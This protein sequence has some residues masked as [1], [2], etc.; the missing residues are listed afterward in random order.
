MSFTVH[1]VVTYTDLE[2]DVKNIDF[3]HCTI[4]ESVKKTV[5]LTNKSILPQQ[6]GFVGV[7]Q[8]SGHDTG[9]RSKWRQTKTYCQSMFFIALY[10]LQKCFLGN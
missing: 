3:G 6:Y 1:A 2:F 10:L 8:V 4:Y 9:Q 5:R 7:P